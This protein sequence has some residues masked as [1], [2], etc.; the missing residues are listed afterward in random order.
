M[1][2]EIMGLLFGWKE[3]Q[4]ALDLSG[5]LLEEQFFLNI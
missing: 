3:H 4:W 2:S 1:N 5:D